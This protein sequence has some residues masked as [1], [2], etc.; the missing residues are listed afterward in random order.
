MKEHPDYKYRPRRKPKPA[1]VHSSPSHKSSGKSDPGLHP[2]SGGGPHHNIHHPGK[3]S[4]GLSPTS[5]MRAIDSFRAATVANMSHSPFSFGQHAQHPTNNPNSSPSQ[6]P[7]HFGEMSPNLPA[8]FSGHDL[9]R[10]L[11][12]ILPS[13]SN[14]ATSALTEALLRASRAGFMGYTHQGPPPSSDEEGGN[15]RSISPNNHNNKG[16]P[17]FF[18]QTQTHPSFMNN[19]H[20]RKLSISPKRKS[21]RSP[22]P[23]PE[24]SPLTSTPPVSTTGLGFTPPYG[25]SGYPFYPGLYPN[26]YLAAYPFLQ[27]PQQGSHGHPMQLHPSLGIVDHH[28]ATEFPGMFLSSSEHSSSSSSSLPKK[29]PVFVVMKE[30]GG[31]LRRSPSPVV[32]VV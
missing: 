4:F 11:P 18:N 15:K 1:M 8:A 23:S 28:H 32:S 17:I 6:H 9:S 16:S 12:S 29:S 25:G 14:V 19:H 5:V 30:P 20:G 10:F 26:P 27:P 7:P 13:S 31:A 24:R 3:F 22:S 21:S 2:M